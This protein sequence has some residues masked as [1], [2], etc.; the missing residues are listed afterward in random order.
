MDSVEINLHSGKQLPPGPYVTLAPELLRAVFISCVDSPSAVQEPSYWSHARNMQWI[1]ITHVCRYWRSVALGYTDLWKRLYFFNP[2]VTKEMI[3]RSKGINLEV[4]IDVSLEIHQS[5]DT[6][7]I[8]PMVLLEL[9]RISMLHLVCQE[10]LE[11]LVD[12][13]VSAAPKL[14]HLYLS[15]F[16]IPDTIFRETPALR[17]LELHDCQFTSSSPSSGSVSSSDSRMGQLP[18]TISQIVSFLRGTPMLHTLIFDRVLP[19]E[20]TYETFPNLVLP[21]LSRLELTSDITSCTSFL[22]HIIF[23]VTADT[24]VTCYLDPREYYDYG[25]LFR[26]F[27]SVKGNRKISVLKFEYEVNSYSSL[28]I[29]CTI[30]H[31]H[32]PAPTNLMFE[33]RTY[34]GEYEIYEDILNT[35]GVTLPLTNP[36]ELDIVGF[37][38]RWP[39]INFDSLPNIHTIRFKAYTRPPEMF[40]AA[41]ADN[42]HPLKLRFLRSLEFFDTRFSRNN[43]STLMDGLKLRL[44]SG[45]PIEYIRLHRC[46]NIETETVMRMKEFVQD[47]EWDRKVFI[48]ELRYLFQ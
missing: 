6:S 12:G 9:Y 2:D 46:S 42:E 22:E 14:E 36:H 13:F 10:P 39:V 15:T 5:I 37:R 43:I 23:P 8:I 24:R 19:Y 33:F 26:T 3:H 40:L 30:T 17:S 28:N 29:L 25:R 41:F 18:S 20:N 35:A 38:W 44:L 21:K 27:L 47:V 1:A 16:H 4:I 11:S 31:S 45:I 7:P 48:D 34:P 32:Q